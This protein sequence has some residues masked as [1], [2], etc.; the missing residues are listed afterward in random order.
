MNDKQIKEII[1]ATLFVS[2]DGIELIEFASKL[3]KSLDE[4]KVL[5]KEIQSELSEDNGIHLITYANK[6]QISSN[7]AYSEQIASILNPI[8]E[9][10]LT[11]AAMQTLGIIAYKQPI[12]RVEIESIRGVSA[13]YA[14]QVLLENNMIEVIGRKDVVG[15]PLVFGTTEEFLKRFDLENLKDLPSYDELL[16]QIELIRSENALKISE[17]LYKEHTISDEEIPEFFDKDASLSAED[18]ERKQEKE[19][20]LGQK[21]KDIDNVIKGA[22]QNTE[23]ILSGNLTAKQEEDSISDDELNDM[24]KKVMGQNS[25][26]QSEDALA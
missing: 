13:D 1:K 12:T 26:H 6:A 22:K 20:L 24:L 18:K 9:K 5:I 23:E 14:V 3:E 17:N 4:I 21:L 7:P 8:R 16:E 10:A 19:E 11:K 25:H 2:G 15:K